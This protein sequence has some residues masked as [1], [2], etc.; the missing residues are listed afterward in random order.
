MKSF[1]KVCLYRQRDG[2]TTF[3]ILYVV[4]LI[5]IDWQRR[6]AARS[7]KRSTDFLKSLAMPKQL[8]S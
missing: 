2:Q 1:H 4:L 6:G 5:G 8:R 7:I 3:L